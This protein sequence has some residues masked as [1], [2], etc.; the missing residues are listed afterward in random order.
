MEIYGGG[1]SLGGDGWGLDEVGGAWVGM[2]GALGLSAV[3]ERG[4]TGRQSRH[5]VERKTMALGPETQL[6]GWPV[7]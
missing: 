3:V 4:V 1:R 6:W 2:G 5:V 7:V